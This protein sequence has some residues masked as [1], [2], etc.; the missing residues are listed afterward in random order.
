MMNHDPSQLQGDIMQRSRTCMAMHHSCF[1]AILR[2]NT[3]AYY[4]S[5]N[6]GKTKAGDCRPSSIAQ[7]T[8]WNVPGAVCGHRLSCQLWC[9]STVPCGKCSSWQSWLTNHWQMPM[10][11]HFYQLDPALISCNL[12]NSLRRTMSCVSD[13]D[14]SL[15]CSMSVLLHLHSFFWGQLIPW[16]WPSGA[17]AACDSSD[18]KFGSLDFRL[19]ASSWLGSWNLTGAGARW[20]RLKRLFLLNPFEPSATE[21]MQNQG[22]FRMVS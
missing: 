5:M 12:R 21:N 9:L 13:I 1:D 14:F 16:C 6:S 3:H 15:M 19:P 8:P 22:M 2:K 7:R 4:F 20:Q 11:M 17:P 10:V 18:P